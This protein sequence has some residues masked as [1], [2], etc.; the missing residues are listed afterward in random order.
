[1]GRFLA[2]V[3]HRLAP[4]GLLLLGGCWCLAATAGPI[5][6]ADT[7]EVDGMVWAQPDLFLDLT[8]NEIN[9][10]CAGGT[11]G[12]GTLAGND[13]AGWSWATVDEMNDLFNQYIGSDELGPGPDFYFGTDTSLSMAF[14]A[15]GWRT[16]LWLFSQSTFGLVSDHSEVW[17]SVTS[18]PCGF[19][20]CS[21][22]SR[23]GTDVVPPGVVSDPGGAWFYRRG[24]EIPLT[25]TLSLMLAALGAFGLL[26]RFRT[27]VEVA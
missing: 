22:V 6:A 8:W 23:F 21:D 14:F 20:G 19:F 26:G 9:A 2:S 11:C 16:E 7:V 24:S 3:T 5:S 1:M 10:V 4:M 25:G 17:A 18:R 13:M 15:D 27:S 12:S